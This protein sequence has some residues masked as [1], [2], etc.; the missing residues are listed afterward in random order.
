MHPGRSWVHSVSL[1]SF[2][3]MLGSLGSLRFF[4]F[5]RVC[6]G[7]RWVH[8]GVPWWSFGS[9][10][11][12]W[13][14]R[15]RPGGRSDHLACCGCRCVHSGSFGSTLGD[16]GFIHGVVGHVRVQPGGCWV[17]SGWLGS[18][19]FALGVGGFVRGCW[20]HSG[21]PFELFGLGFVRVRTGCRLVHSGSLG[22]LRC[23][24]GVVEIIRG[25]WV[26]SG[27]P[28]VSF[29]FVRVHPGCSCVQ[30]GSLGSFGYNLGVVLFIQ[31]RWN[32]LDAP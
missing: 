9:F 19:K 5:I 13:F 7:G 2:G 11:V 4:G 6:P 22:S 12:L 16:V 14:V 24:M 28:W 1:G 10:G 25:H 31:G 30:T 3:C 21:A 17:H 20:I 23:A 29:L 26:C 18:F 8:F 32:D 15:M 27:V